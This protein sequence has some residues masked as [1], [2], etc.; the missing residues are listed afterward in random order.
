MQQASQSLE[1]SL[2]TS[3]DAKKFDAEEDTFGDLEKGGKS[4]SKL[5]FDM[6][7]TIEEAEGKIKTSGEGKISSINETEI[8]ASLMGAGVKIKATKSEQLLKIVNTGDKGFNFQI[9]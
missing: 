1:T 2:T 9:Q 3:S 5:G 6:K 8:I 4:E 7:F